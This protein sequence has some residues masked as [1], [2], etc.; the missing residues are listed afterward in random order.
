MWIKFMFS[1]KSEKK[2]LEN[3]FVW[4]T[5][6]SSAKQVKG[7]SALLEVGKCDQIHLTATKMMEK[8]R[9]CNYKFL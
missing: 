6:A 3:W 2:M 5:N 4:K 9:N 8:I 7:W 1:G